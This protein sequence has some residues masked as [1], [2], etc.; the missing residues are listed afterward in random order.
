VAVAE[1]VREIPSPLAP[2]E[3]LHLSLQNEVDAAI[4]RSQTWLLAQQHPSG[5]WG[6]SNQLATAYAVIALQL[7]GET[8]AAA[9]GRRWLQASPATNSFWIAMAGGKPAPP[10]PSQH[11]AADHPCVVDVSKFAQF[12][13]RQAFMLAEI[14][15]AIPHGLLVSPQGWR[16]KI[17]VR[18]VAQQRFTPQTPGGAY[19]PEA[20]PLSTESDPVS[21]TALAMIILLQL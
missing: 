8:N 2:G 19:W 21:Q 9:L 17:A 13:G 6:A 1:T 5:F 20:T 10:H 3:G 12:S 15:R 7:C 11:L 14:N 16:E 18:V 4:G